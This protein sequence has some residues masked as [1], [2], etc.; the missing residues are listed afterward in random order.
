MAKIRYNIIRF[1]VERSRQIVKFSH[2]IPPYLDQC[3]GFIAK[4][5]KGIVSPVAI[6]ELGWLIASFNSL[7]EQTIV[8]L[9]SAPAQNDSD[10]RYDYQTLDIELKKGQLVLGVYIDTMPAISFKPY[11]VS[12]YLRC[13]TSD[14]AIKKETAK[15]ASKTDEPIEETETH[16]ETEECEIPEPKIEPELEF[17]EFEQG[18]LCMIT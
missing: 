6:A 12:L 18:H 1:Q 16:P 10:D 5:T 11:S 2:K 4:H 13:E 14:P 7:K 17:N 15:K 3:T 9:I 8:T